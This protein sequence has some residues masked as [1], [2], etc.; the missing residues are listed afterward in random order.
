[1]L[2]GLEPKADTNDSGTAKVSATESS[3]SSSIAAIRS[4]WKVADILRRP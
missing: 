3:V 4:E 2:A 1:M